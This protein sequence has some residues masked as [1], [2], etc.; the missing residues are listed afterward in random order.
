[1][2]P[3]YRLKPLEVPRRRTLFCMSAFLL[4]HKKTRPTG[5]VIAEALGIRHGVNPDNIPTGTTKVIR[6][7]NA[8]TIR[9][10]GVEFLN[11]AS[12]I[13]LAGDKLAPLQKLNEAGVP[14]VEFVTQRPD[15]PDA[16]V[17]FGRKKRGFG[18]HDIVALNNHGAWIPGTNYSG[19]NGPSALEKLRA[20]EFF[21][22]YVENSRE[23]RIHVVNGN[24]VRY[25]RKYPL[26][27]ARPAPVRVQNHKNG[28]VFQQPR[29]RLHAERTDAC[30]A[31]VE[32]LGLDFGAVDMIV[33]LSA[34]DRGRTVVLEVNTAPSCSPKTAEAYVNALREVL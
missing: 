23:Y 8:K 32:A 20:C 19:Y 21:T 2:Q 30:I 10:P 24:I 5:R 13:M 28:Y 33:D 25:Q 14:H 12:S 4:Y 3:T 34:G 26:A 16:S 17:W 22:R 1:M 31:A 27:A 9:T 15:H 7:G 18:G 29:Q 6:W 11:S